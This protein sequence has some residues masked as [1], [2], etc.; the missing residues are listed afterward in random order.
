MNLDPRAGRHIAE[1]ILEGLVAV[2]AGLADSVR[3][4]TTPPTSSASTEAEARWKE[5]GAR[6]AGTKVVTYHQEFDYLAALYG[7]EIAGTVE[8]KP[9]IPPTPT[10]LA[11]LSRD[12]EGGRS[13][14]R[15][16]TAAWSNNKHV[17]RASRR[18]VGGARAR[19]ADAGRRRARL[20]TRGSR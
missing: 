10:H 18:S 9:G 16:L 13:A 17:R 4:A 8:P 6:L 3:G 14:R 7:I 12:D 15:S 5:I 20:Q 2:D 11:R 1:R 19:A